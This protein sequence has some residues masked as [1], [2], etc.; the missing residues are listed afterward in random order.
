MELNN[1]T[2]QNNNLM[3]PNPMNNLMYNNMMTRPMNNSM[4]NDMVANPMNNLM[5]NGMIPYP[6][7]NIMNNNM[8]PNTMNNIMN[9]NMISNTMN[10]ALNNYMIPN[11]I[12]NNNINNNDKI[13]N[14]ENI[15]IENATKIELD[16]NEIIKYYL[17]P[18][19][20]FTEEEKKNS[21]VLLVIGKTGHGKTTFI[22]ALVNIYLGININDKF[23]YLLAQNEN[24]ENN[25]LDSK[26]KEITI[27]K[28]RPKRG[29]NFPPLIIIDT[30]GFSD[31]GGKEQDKNHLEEFHKLFGS[32]EIKN[33]NCILYIIIA[34]DPRFGENE[35][36]IIDNLLNLFSKNVKENF[37]VGVTN[38]IGNKKD[39]PNIIN[40]LSNE[41][42]FYYQNVLKNDELSR[43]QVINSYWYF[44]S[45]NKIIS[46][47]KIERDELDKVKWK[48]TEKQIK[49]FIEKKIKNL[50][51]KKLK[52]SEE[53]LN[54][55]FQLKNEMISF[56]EK[57]NVLI[58]K[59][60]VNEDNLKKQNEYRE[61]ITEIKDKIEKNKEEKEYILQTLKGIKNALPYMKTIKNLKYNTKEE[62]LIC[63]I[64]NLNCHKNCNC[65]I[66]KWFCNMISFSGECKICKHHFSY[67]KKEKFI[68]IQKG[69]NEPLINN[70]N[71]EELDYYINFLSE[72]KK[73]KEFHLEGINEGNS[74]LKNT[75]NYLNNQIRICNERIEEGEEHNLSLENEIIEALNKIKKNLDFLR[76]N[77]LNKEKRTIQ[78]YIEEYKRSK[79]EK[80]K[81][82][83]DNLFQKYQEQ[84]LN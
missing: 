39:I 77:A 44:A 20:E 16:N 6:M 84:N 29:L 79:D 13:N 22:N 24:K 43:E 9:N 49:N 28:I 40:S 52:D 61:L 25:Q 11:P 80:E 57:I 63:E 33:I 64:C 68:Y 36:Y 83:I 76:S 2:N 53:V 48:Y 42:H 31:T 30:P 41:N 71:N 69:E 81:E 78:I 58:L 15:P 5:Y 34:A 26:T 82:I 59:I 50:D 17:Y 67:H 18:K 55:R 46:D 45:D 14:I 35:K 38:F 74:V 66:S 70:E 65:I 51:K 62:N 27:Y 10:N 4:Y 47:N 8:I 3:M 56:T 7:N 73:Q 32:D 12:N 21:K 75:L 19:I 37:V 54:N 23:R 1:Q 60:K 72:T